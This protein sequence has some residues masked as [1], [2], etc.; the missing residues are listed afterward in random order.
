MN[1]RLSYPE[2]VS[3]MPKGAHPWP[4]G[5]LNTPGRSQAAKRRRGVPSSTP[6]DGQCG[7][8]LAQDVNAL[9]PVIWLQRHSLENNRFEY[10]W[11]VGSMLS[12]R[13][14]LPFD[15]LKRDLNGIFA[16]VGRCAG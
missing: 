5:C 3:L 15:M 12:R 8:G 10:G 1:K 6:S 7:E 13:F 4:D 14:G 16:N 2:R 11:E 9:K